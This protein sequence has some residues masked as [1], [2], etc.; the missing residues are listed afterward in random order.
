MILDGRIFFIFLFVTL[1]LEYENHERVGCLSVD[2][3]GYP[4]PLYSLQTDNLI[5][6]P[7]STE[8]QYSNN[9]TEIAAQRNIIFL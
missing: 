9:I 3:F 6:V 2:M 4:P 7:Q 8:Y 5:I 1:R